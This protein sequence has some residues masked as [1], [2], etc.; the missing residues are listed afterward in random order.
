MTKSQKIRNRMR[1]WIKI[2]NLKQIIILKEATKKEKKEGM[3]SGYT[4]RKNNKIIIG[5]NPNI[6]TLRNLSN[7]VD[8]VILHEIGHILTKQ[9]PGMNPK[10]KKISVT[11]EYRAEKYMLHILYKYNMRLYKKVINYMKDFLSNE[12]SMYCFQYPEHYH[13]FCKVYN[14]KR[15]DI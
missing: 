11:K 14:I 12:Y 15:I 13:A 9:E 6:I 7:H 2:L 10:E 1:Y 4:E 8:R 5:F 3:F